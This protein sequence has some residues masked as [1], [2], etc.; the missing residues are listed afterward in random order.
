MLAAALLPAA[1]LALA[2]ASPA[3]DE[4]AWR[5]VL[6]YDEV[7]VHLDATSVKG[8]GPYTVRL[9]WSFTVRAASPRAWDAGVRYSID[10]VE[11]DCSAGATR[12]WASAAFQ[13]NGDLVPTLSFEESA[14]L[15]SRHRAES[16][17]A[18][19]AREACAMLR[20]RN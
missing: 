20:A 19:L 3:D 14:P 8:T 7:A 10:A 5:P 15:W 9:R 18:L 2:A 16:M 6:T 17:G 12:T 4:S 11:I 1:M 13:S